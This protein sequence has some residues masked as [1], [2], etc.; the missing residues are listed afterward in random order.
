ML[1]VRLLE[2]FATRLRSQGVP[3][4]DVAQ[5]GL[6]DQTMQE[7][8]SPL[9]L[10]LPLEARVWW[11][12]RNGVPE[13]AGAGRTE[14][15]PGRKWLPLDEAVAECSQIRQM[16]AEAAGGEQRLTEAAWA[17]SWIPLVRAEGSIVIETDVPDNAPS[18]VRV[19]WFDEPAAPPDL[20]S[21]GEAVSL[22]IEAMDQGAWRYDHHQDRWEVDHEIRASLRAAKR[23]LI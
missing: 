22:W 4:I 8:V 1:T 20:A 2:Q 3:A 12:W 18:P 16:L 15:G 23:G 5:P 7:L 21:L 10:T 19:Y 17:S 6:T 13:T 9:G 11:G 14:I